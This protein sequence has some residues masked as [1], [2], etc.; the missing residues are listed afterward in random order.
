LLPA[1]PDDRARARWLEE[2]ADTRLGDLCIWGLFYQRVVGPIVWGEP[3][4]EARIE[5]TLNEGL[6]AALDYLENEAPGGG[7]RFGG[8]GLADIAV[9]SF[10]RN[11]AYAGFEIDAARWPKAAAWVARTLDHDC[12][13]RFLKFERAQLSTSPQ[14]RRRALLDA[15]APLVDESVGGREPRRGLMAL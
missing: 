1:A 4:D 15:G 10:F 6:P 14:G 8:I 11:A 2:F 3:A 5:T 13:D 7:F 9:A 12:I